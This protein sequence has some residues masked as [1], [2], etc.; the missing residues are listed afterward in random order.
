MAE[1]SEKAQARRKDPPSRA[2]L[3][4]AMKGFVVPKPPSRKRR[5]TE[6]ER[7]SPPP[8]LRR[9]RCSTLAARRTA[10]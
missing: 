8:R 5:C 2:S 6:V 4:A 7:H 1:F 3:P 10:L 9:S